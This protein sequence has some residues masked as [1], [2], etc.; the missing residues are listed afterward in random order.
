VIARQDD[1]WGERPLLVVEREGDG[2]AATL[3]GL[4]HG[5]VADWWI[6]DQI[7]DVA[8]MPLAS[9]GKIDKARLRADLADGTLVVEPA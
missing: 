9:T 4:L 3:L 2:N 6:P 5:K 8:T 7:A 1:K